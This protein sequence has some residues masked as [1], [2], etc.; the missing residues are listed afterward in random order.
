[1]KMTKINH[2]MTRRHVSWD[3]TQRAIYMVTITLKD[4]T[5]E[6]L[7]RLQK[8]TET[9]NYSSE[10]WFLQP[11]E[12]GICA[13]KA[14]DVMPQLYPQIDIV[15]KQ[16]M[17]DHIHFIVFVKSQLPKP[18]GA[19]IKGFKAGSTKLWKDLTNIGIDSSLDNN[20]PISDLHPSWS[21]GYTDKILF[22]KMQYYKMIK[23][24][25]D[26][27]RRLAEK[28]KNP[29]LFQQVSESTISLCNEKMKGKFQVLGNRFLLDFPM[30]H[31]QCS[32]KYF[33]YRRVLGQNGFKKIVLNF[34]GESI[35]EKRTQEF[36]EILNSVLNSAKQGYVVLN[37]C[38]S[39]G[40]REIAREILK[41]NLPMIVLKNMGFS[42]YGKPQGKYF[43]ACA[44]GK[45]LFLTPIGWPYQTNRKSMTRIDAMVLNRI[46]QWLAGENDI[47]LNYNG[48]KIDNINEIA[49]TIINAEYNTAPRMPQHGTN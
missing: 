10:K 17:P 43:D 42:R 32:R 46:A 41:Q 14:L 26:N 36:M 37:P 15:E 25:K 30:I 29:F 39:D 21:E 33:S 47:E 20:T 34:N 16:L 7:G 11:S 12:F 31:V 27:P 9:N 49:A 3:Y 18:L 44:K 22:G 1:M 8:S 23:Y 4:R 5:R 45:I 48:Y 2:T 38:I 35:V 6:W 19:L 40:E 28:R 24:L 13:L